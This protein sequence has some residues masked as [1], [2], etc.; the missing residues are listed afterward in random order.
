MIALFLTL[1]LAAPAASLLPVPPLPTLALTLRS[2][3]LSA[4]ALG[5]KGDGTTDDTAA[6]QLGLSL[7]S[8]TNNHTLFIE[9]GTYKITSTLLLNRTLGALVQGTGATTILLW[10]GPAAGVPPETQSRMLWSD[11]NTRFE[12]NGLTFD[13]ANIAGVGLDHD[14]KNQYESRV[15]HQNLAFFR[16][17]AAG[18]RTGHAQFVASAEMTFVN[19]LF[20]YN[21]AGVFFGSWKLVHG[22]PICLR[23]LLSPLLSP[24]F[25]LPPLFPL[26]ILFSDYDNFFNLCHF[27]QNQIGIQMP[28]GNIYVHNTRFELSNVSDTTYCGHASSFRRVVSVNSTRF[29]YPA[30]EGGASP[31]K[32]QGSLIYGWGATQ[33]QS[34]DPD[35]AIP[36]IRIIVGGPFQVFDTVFESPVDNTSSAFAPNCG[37]AR[38]DCGIPFLI[39]NLTRRGE[40]GPVFD[41]GSSFNETNDVRVV[42]GGDPA[43]AALLPTLTHTTQFF[44]STWPTLVGGKLLDAIVDFHAD[45]SGRNDSTPALQACVDAAAGAAAGGVVGGGCYIPAGSYSLNSTLRLCGSGYTLVGA[46]DGYSGSQL[47]WMPGAPGPGITLAVGPSAGCTTPTNVTLSHLNV[48]G[49]AAP[50]GCSG[51]GGGGGSGSGSGSDTL[52]C[53]LALLV[54]RDPKVPASPSGRHAAM[55]LPPA[56][57]PLVLH[58]TTTTTASATVAV[59]IDSVFW[60]GVGGAVLNGLG[61]GDVVKGPLWDGDLEVFDSDSAVVLASFLSEGSDGWTVARALPYTPAPPL[62]YLGASV[63]ISSASHFDQR[64][65]NSSWLTIADTYTET[66]NSNTYLE[67]QP[68]DFPGQVVVSYAKLNGGPNGAPQW[69]VMANNYTGFYYATGALFQHG[70]NPLAL[71]NG[72]APFNLLVTSSAVDAGYTINLTSTNPN[73]VLQKMS[74]YDVQGDATVGTERVLT[75]K[76]L[77]R[78][79]MHGYYDMMLNCPWVLL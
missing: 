31:T 7:L 54:G 16:F 32:I 6:L 49:G 38:G 79:R 44:T 41:P 18:I 42:P 70:V 74:N 57:V 71:A 68:G 3:W 21:Y 69:W 66:Q 56:A 11:G 72:S 25:P 33:D 76:A 78:L 36:A 1:I 26:P 47:G 55:T 37:G 60:G 9:A 50:S 14:S 29:L 77:D 17:T 40:Q 27:S 75:A 73:A 20:A 15:V 19:C 12:I 53:G 48:A 58:P 64:V 39:S 24:H 63:Y 35:N 22:S 59:V 62:G 67:G 45:P 51:S 43:I 30:S 13:G 23:L 10:G 8:T 46:G 28:A 65:F 52:P 2:D 4:R 34:D 61:S 5:A